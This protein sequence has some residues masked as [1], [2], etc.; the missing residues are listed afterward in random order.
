MSPDTSGTYR[1]GEMSGEIPTEWLDVIN[2]E[3]ISKVPN[4]TALAKIAGNNPWLCAQYFD[5]IMKLIVDVLFNW[6]EKA[7][8][9]RVG[10]GLFGHT[11]AFVVSTESQQSGKL[12]GLLYLR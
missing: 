11:K 12:S 7:Q 1:I 2:E 4:R 5:Y 8:S 10:G 6:D 3:F 9:S